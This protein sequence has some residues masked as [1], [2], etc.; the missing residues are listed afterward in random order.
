MDPGPLEVTN[1]IQGQWNTH[2]ENRINMH[3]PHDCPVRHIASRL[4]LLGVFPLFWYLTTSEHVFS[5][6]YSA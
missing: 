6:A 5:R 3:G 4:S 2:M 1:A